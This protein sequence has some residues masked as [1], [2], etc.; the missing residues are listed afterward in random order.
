M[1]YIKN[2]NLVHLTLLNHGVKRCGWFHNVT[3]ADQMAQVSL[4][5]WSIFFIF[6]E[7]TLKFRIISILSI[8]QPKIILPTACTTKKLSCLHLTED[9]TMSADLILP[10]PGNQHWKSYLAP[11]HLQAFLYINCTVFF[12]NHFSCYCLK[13]AMVF[14]VPRPGMK[15]NCVSSIP[16]CFLVN[17]SITLNYL[18]L[19]VSFPYSFFL[20]HLIL[21]YNRLQ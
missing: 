3:C 21:S 11:T 18:D 15:P 7:P 20:K 17:F 14:V 12:V 4:T 6:R 13:I 2:K 16:T 5:W 8:D 10:G 19:L 9:L 1:K